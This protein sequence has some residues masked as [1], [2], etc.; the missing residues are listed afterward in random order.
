MDRVQTRLELS[1]STIWKV[2]F[3][4]LLL[5]AVLWFLDG[6]RQIVSWFLVALFLA[7]ALAPAVRWL[8][9]KGLR[10][11]FGVLAVFTLAAVLVTGLMVTLVPMLI[12]Q[13]RALQQAAP[14]LLSKVESNEWIQKMDQRYGVLQRAQQELAEFAPDAAGPV[15]AAVANVLKG[16]LAL[17]TVTALTVFMLLFGKEVFERA[18]LWLHPT[19]RPRF[20]RL[21]R[22]MIRSVGG[23]VAGTLLIA[24]IGGVVTALGMLLLGVP[25]FLPLG[26][27]MGLLAI[28]PFVGT[29]IAAVLV[30]G[31]TFATAGV[32]AGIIAVVGFLVYQQIE[33]HLLQPVVQRKTLKMNPLL[34]ALAM[35]FGTA[36]GGILGALLALP[37]AGAIQVILQDVLAR[38]HERWAAEMGATPVFHADNTA[39]PPAAAEEAPG[40]MEDAGGPQAHH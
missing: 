20:E 18:L 16:A 39:L 9:K 7:V 1:A 23:Y 2:L 15:L 10:R 26:F 37:I 29:A 32:Q 12:E 36:F 40:G 22:Q 30:V 17:V 28:I 19:R 24:L 6:A 5:A 13:G 11:G 27:L 31:T 4:L 38:R 33:G 21:A 34:I 14:D 35:L 8:E 25:Y 3:N